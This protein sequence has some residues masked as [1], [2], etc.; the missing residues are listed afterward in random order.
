MDQTAD[1]FLKRFSAFFFSFLLIK[2]KIPPFT[3][4]KFGS[5]FENENVID[6]YLWGMMRKRKTK[7]NRGSKESSGE[8]EEE[9]RVRGGK[10]SAVIV[11]GKKQ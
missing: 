6:R 4:L 2:P 7:F 9:E 8:E 11:S 1:E 5:F 3:K 10:S